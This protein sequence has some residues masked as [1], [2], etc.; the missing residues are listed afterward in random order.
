MPVALL[1]NLRSYFLD[2][3]LPDAV[4]EI[5]T[6]YLAALRV[7]SGKRPLRDRVILPFTASPIVPSFEHPNIVDRP[8]LASGIEEAKRKLRLDGGRVALIVP[9]PSFRVIVLAVDALPASQAERE[10]FIRWRIA[11]QMPA[12]PEDVRLDYA[13]AGGPVSKKVMAAMARASVVAEFEELF[14][15]AGLQ[16]GVLTV[17][18]LSLVNLIVSEPRPDGILLNI[19]DDHMS[20]VAFMDTEWIL[21]RQKGIQTGGRPSWT[22]D[23]R[24]GQVS[25]ELE[26]TVHFL[27]DR[28]Q[29][30][31]E[32]IWVRVACFENGVE[33]ESRLTGQFSAP[34]ELIENE[35]PGDWDAREKAILAPLMGQLR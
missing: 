4:F 7:P 32:K 31:V 21:Y 17:P 5:A 30:R 9:D 23:Q 27:E 33:A 24:I 20:L 16:V 29:R 35:V 1:D 13:V 18:S 22:L 19:A 10:T 14:A 8:A 2:R 28:E 11:K 25:Q 15:R 26:N 3:P 12:L 34:I 6:D